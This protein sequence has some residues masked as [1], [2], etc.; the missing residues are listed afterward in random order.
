DSHQFIWS[1]LATDVDFAPDGSL[2]VTD[3]V[4]GWVGEGK[5]RIYRFTDDVGAKQIAENN[6]V[7]LLAGKISQLSVDEVRDLLSNVD[8]RVR[9]EAQFELVRRNVSDELIA[10]ALQTTNELRSRHAIRGCRQLGL[11]SGADADRIYPVMEQ[12][13][14]SDGI[15]ESL[16]VEALRTI[17]D[18][19]DR[20][21]LQQ[22]NAQQSAALLEIVT[23]R[24]T[25]PSL[26][27]AG[28]AA[29]ATG[30][31][32]TAAD[33]GALL[34]L[35]DRADNQD[36]VVR[37]QAS[38]GLAFLAAR[39]PGLLQS[40]SVHPG[41]AGR[42]GIVLAMRRLQDP[43][44]GSFLSDADGRVIMEAAR[45]IND[46]PIE[47]AQP[48][49]AQLITRPGLSEVTLR[50]ALNA[51]YRQ[52][53][54]QD[55]A[56]VAAIAA[57]P[58][59]SAAIR[60]VA[61]RM[62]ENWNNTDP[63]DTVTGRWNP[64]PTR[65]V[66]GLADAVRPSLPGM[67]AG[68]EP[69][70]ESAIRLASQL[71]ITDVVPALQI[72]LAH[73]QNPAALRVSAF[74]ALSVL[75]GD[76]DQLIQRG[77]QDASE[78]IRMAAIEVLVKRRPADAITPLR[79]SLADGVLTTKQR[80]I[81]LL[82]EI[83]N[84]SA[85]QILLSALVSLQKGEIPRGVALDLLNAAATRKTDEFTGAIKAW[86]Q[87]QAEAGTV[88]ALWDECL[89]GG[90][91]ERGREIF[92]GRSA[93]SC[94]RCHKISG[95]GGE[96]GPDLSAIGKDKDRNYLLEAIVDP[97]AKIAK[98]FETAVIATAE[99]Q[100]LAGIVRGED[101]QTLQLMTPQG[102]IV[103]VAK[104]DIDDRAVGQSGMP[105]DISKNLTRAEIRDLVAF[106]ATLQTESTGAHGK[107]GE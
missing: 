19:V 32:G 2:Y 51:C 89:E 30:K 106:L 46:E 49:L 54:T 35:L 67:L 102:A 61:A 53:T 72:L 44:V 20:H 74:Q 50:N 48:E 76:V 75:E 7:A 65:R 66:T 88:L 4:N 96:V 90:D 16:Q 101:D 63:I 11:R 45:A 18:L 55:A 78:P 77:L 58:S 9:Q 87:R 43:A 107:T 81:E 33:A 37:H 73:E 98:G 28:F 84:E 83:G 80:A 56:S 92:F 95:S 34:K 13:L 21:G 85:D 70:R 64:L 14:R 27:L 40:L 38:M 60:Q 6:S 12:L 41:D 82:S 105:A 31:L 39:E 10:D 68:P 29:V 100:I 86:R 59:A 1:I 47:A 25:S 57:H 5:G 79:D 17:C 97:N 71:G 24:T 69:I 62:L 103:T 104:S 3:W 8:R 99:G 26:R 36:P 91:A 23:A 93:A 15:A 42:L 52:G 94:R 22:L